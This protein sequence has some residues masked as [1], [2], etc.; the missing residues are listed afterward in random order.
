MSFPIGL[1]IVCNVSIQIVFGRKKIYMKYKKSEE[2]F[3]ITDR[4][5]EKKKKVNQARAG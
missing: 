3:F 2:Q 4:L 5:F 1:H